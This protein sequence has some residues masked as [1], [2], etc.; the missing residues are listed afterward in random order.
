MTGVSRLPE[1]Y[2]VVLMNKKKRDE[3]ISIIPGETN[4]RGFKVESV[5]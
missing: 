1:G 2:F 3:W 4:P 5:M